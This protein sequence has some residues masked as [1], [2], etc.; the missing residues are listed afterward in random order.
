MLKE[1]LGD[2]NKIFRN[3]VAPSATAIDEASSIDENAEF[4]SLRPVQLPNYQLITPSSAILT[5]VS[6]RLYYDL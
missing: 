2:T 3:Q 1:L 6:D 5:A 4:N